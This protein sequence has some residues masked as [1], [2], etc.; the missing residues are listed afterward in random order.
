MQNNNNQSGREWDSFFRTS[1]Q[2]MNTEVG[3]MGNSS[4][5]DSKWHDTV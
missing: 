4:T 1:A 5:I 2:K 3:S